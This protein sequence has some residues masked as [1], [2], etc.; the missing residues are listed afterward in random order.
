MLTPEKMA[1]SPLIIFFASAG[2]LSAAI[3]VAFIAALDMICIDMK[4]T[5]NRGKNFSN[6]LK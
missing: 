2:S 3:N 5:A 4:I 6:K 1:L